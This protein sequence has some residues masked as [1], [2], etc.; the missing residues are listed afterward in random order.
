MSGGGRSEFTCLYSVTVTTY[1]LFQGHDSVD[2]NVPLLTRVG[3]PSR[4][5]EEKPGPKKLQ[6][7]AECY[8][9][10]EGLTCRVAHDGVVC[11]KVNDPGS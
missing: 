1:L 5:R 10:G 4:P 8:L 6:A 3:D 2:A 11:K 7:P 9:Y